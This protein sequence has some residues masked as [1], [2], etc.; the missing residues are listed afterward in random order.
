MANKGAQM[1]EMQKR[2]DFVEHQLRELE[3]LK[4]KEKSL[5]KEA[6]ELAAKIADMKSEGEFFGVDE[7]DKDT[8]PYKQPPAV[9][10]DAKGEKLAKMKAIN[11]K[12]KQIEALKEKDDLDAD[13]QAKVASEGELRKQLAALE[14]GED[15]VKGANDDN[16]DDAQ[17]ERV[18]LPTDA[19]ERDKRLKNLKKKLQQIA[20]LKAKD[21]VLDAQAKEKVASE[22]FINQEV[23]ALEA[24]RKEVILM[25]KTADEEKIDLE[26]KI[27][28][29][30]KKIESVQKLKGQSGL[31]ADQQAKVD[32]EKDMVREVNE[33]QRQVAALNKK[34]A[35]RVAQR[36]GFE[37]E[38]GKKKG[39]K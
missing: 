2:L 23:A 28:S 29:L 36:L 3:E 38:N 20:E 4:A 12:L 10:R 14:A 25:P 35:E 32:S 37:A 5:K 27:K 8:E 19:D 33:L 16:G 24:G 1:R 26:K 22:H 39:K 31:D 21:G 11:K 17:G 9:P 18:V 34:E 30:N 13:A 7:E 6:T 15:Y